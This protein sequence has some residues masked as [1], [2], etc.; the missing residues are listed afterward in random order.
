MNALLASSDCGLRSSA[1]VT[2]QRSLNDTFRKPQYAQTDR[3][4]CERAA[5]PPWGSG[6]AR[7]GGRGG[8]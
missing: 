7:R 6:A 2:E 1:S 8:Q 3:S 4:A 5:P